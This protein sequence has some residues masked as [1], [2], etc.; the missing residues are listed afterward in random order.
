MR[1]TCPR[2]FGLNTLPSI[3]QQLTVFLQ[4]LPDDAHP[5]VFNQDLVGFFT[6]IPVYRIFNAVRWAVIEYCMHRRQT[7]TV[8]LC[9]RIFGNFGVDVRKRLQNALSSS[10]LQTL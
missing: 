9:Q 2:S 6:S 10:T 8:S 4:Q 3:L 1:T 7:L 5:V